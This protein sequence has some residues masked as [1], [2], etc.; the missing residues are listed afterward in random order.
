MDVGV[1]EG[2]VMYSKGLNIKVLY[3]LVDESYEC[4]TERAIE[5]DNIGFLDKDFCLLV[6][7]KVKKGSLLRLEIQLG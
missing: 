2:Q 3:K 5:A 6:K 4:G 1:Q 7:N